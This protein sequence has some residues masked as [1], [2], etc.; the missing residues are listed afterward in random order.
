MADKNSPNKENTV[1]NSWSLNQTTP[2]DKTNTYCH[3]RSSHES[4]AIVRT[5]TWSILN[6][7]RPNEHQLVDFEH[8]LTAKTGDSCDFEQFRTSI[9]STEAFLNTG[10]EFRRWGLGFRGFLEVKRNW[11]MEFEH[12]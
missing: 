12:V 7:R 2:E 1:A 9:T 11:V 6:S 3:T 4:T 10:C 8:K 5:E